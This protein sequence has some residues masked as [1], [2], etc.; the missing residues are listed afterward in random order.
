MILK[1][2]G[3]HAQFIIAYT[4]QQNGVAERHM[5]TIMERVRALLLNGK[6]PKPIWAECVCHVTTLI[7]MTPS[8]KTDGR[9]P[10]ELWYRRIPSV[11]Y[12][13]VFGC[14]VYVHI[15]EQYPD[16]LD[17]R[18]RLCMYLG[19]PG[20]K[21]GYHLIDINT[22]AIVYSR[23]VG[24]KEDEFPPLADLTFNFGTT[25]SVQTDPL[26]T[27]TAPAPAMTPPADIASVPTLSA[28]PDAS[29]ITV[30]HKL[31]SLRE[32]PDGNEIHYY[33]RTEVKSD[34]FSPPA[35]KR[36]RL[37]KDDDKVSLNSKKDQQEH[38]QRVH[39]TSY[40]VCDRAAQA[41]KTAQAKR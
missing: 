2:Y 26:A 10:Y 33:F 12:M 7:N 31:P 39:I 25:S 13:K 30:L 17:A 37:T 32:A 1:K 9:A 41:T 34:S 28:G 23:D 15:T 24:L 11:T 18:P 16:K 20:H 38:E 22:H 21:K 27:I 36:P 8:S 29:T 3:T 35:S 40:S 6:L 4:P 5:R 14:S 19:I